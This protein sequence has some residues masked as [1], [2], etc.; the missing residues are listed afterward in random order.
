MKK[1]QEKKLKLLSKWKQQQKSE[2][3]KQKQK[4][5]LNKLIS[6]TLCKVK[7]QKHKKKT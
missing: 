2:H 7:R 4:T 5:V 1:Q 3:E 6:L